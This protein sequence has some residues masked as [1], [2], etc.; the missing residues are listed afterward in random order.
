VRANDRGDL[1][2]TKGD[3]YD[4]REKDGDRDVRNLGKPVDLAARYFE[5]GTDEIAFLNITAF[6]DFP[7]ADQPMLEVLKRASERVFV[8]LTI[9]GGIRAFTDG[10]GR[11]YSA[12]DVAHEYFRSGADKVSIGSDAVD[13]VERYRAR[14]GKDGSSSIEQIAAV[15]GNQAVVISVDPRRVYVDSPDSTPRVTVETAIPGPNGERYCWFQCTVKG[16]RE[17][18]DVDAVEL[19][20]VCEDLGAGEILLNSIDRDGT[21]IGFDLELIAAVSEAVTIPVI[22]SSGAGRVE[23][24]AEV[25]EATGVEAAL[26]AGIFHRREVPIAAVKAH[27][28]ERGIEIRG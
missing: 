6:R 21:G 25:F 7:L 16:G 19:A 17:G 5:E 26:A 15:Y 23:H 20:R 4:V 27:L 2:V 28:R 10:E 1:V 3:Q 24:F 18:R 13:E 14:G 12:L 22:A 8:P 9:G 11:Y